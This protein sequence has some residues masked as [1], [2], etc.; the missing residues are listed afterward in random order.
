VDVFVANQTEAEKYAAVLQPGSY[1]SITVGRL[2]IGR[3]R[4]Y[5][6]DFYGAG[7]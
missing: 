4:D 1:S 2:G 5:I 7:G 6:L 3:Q